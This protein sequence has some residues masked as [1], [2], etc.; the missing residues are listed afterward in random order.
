MVKNLKK[1]SIIL[2]ALTF[3]ILFLVLKDD[4][5]SIIGLLK[6]ANPLWLLIACIFQL[7][8]FFFESLAFDQIIKSYKKEH[9]FIKTFKLTL[10]TKFFNGI[11]PFS[12]GGQPMQ[13]YYL[14]QEGFRITKAT[15]MIMQNFILYQLA[16]VS[17][18]LFAITTNYIFNYFEKIP[19][20]RYLVT[21]G[22]IINTLVMVVLFIIS[23]SNKFNKTI[24]QLAIQLGTKLKIIKDPE[25]QKEKWLERCNDFHEGA[26]YIKEHKL[27][28]LKGYIYYILNLVCLY[29]TPYFIFKALDPTLSL[30]VITTIV[31]SS[32]VLIIGSFV[33]IPGAS[34]GIEYGFLRFFNHF[35]SGSI[36]SASLLI[37][38]TITY[39]LPMIVGAIALNVRKETKL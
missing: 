37:W 1:N 8:V 22:F 12:T 36:V 27:L 23:F 14:K 16:L 25:K 6:N 15:N 11:T 19:F 5:S 21:I 30:S 2:L 4:F 7:G 33:P 18:G 24:I 10:V 38:R 32:Y 13:V 28:C 31:A 39:Y 35:A 3:I 34:G 20:L 26:T 29:I 17:M 9:S